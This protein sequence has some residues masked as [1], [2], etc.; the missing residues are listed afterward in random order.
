[1]S[2]ETVV[3]ED[4]REMKMSKAQAQ[5]GRNY[6]VRH[7]WQPEVFIEIL[8]LVRRLRVAGGVRYLGLGEMFM[9]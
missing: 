6:C 7:V 5:R 8:V 3:S 4:Q 1:M 2:V 9:C